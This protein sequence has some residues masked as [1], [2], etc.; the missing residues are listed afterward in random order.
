MKPA[1]LL[2]ALCGFVASC[3]RTSEPSSENEKKSVPFTA[4]ELIDRCIAYHDPQ[5]LWANFAG[6]LRCVNVRSNVIYDEILEINN[7]TGYYK[8]SLKA[9]DAKIIRGI[10]NNVAFRSVDGDSTLTE[11]EMQ[12][13]G[14]TD[15]M[16]RFWN[17]V[18][19]NHFGLPMEIRKSGISLSDSVETEKFDDRECFVIKGTGKKDSVVNPFYEGEWKIYIDS[20]NFSVRGIEVKSAMFNTTYIIAFEGTLNLNG[21]IL[22]KVKIGSDKNDPW[23]VS[24]DVFTAVAN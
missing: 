10:K 15:P 24:T 11:K 8:S 23:L 2:L 12:D 17:T 9:P 1:L 14:L 5:G 22:P 4:S 6:K 7:T 18:H 20:Q 16:I 3:N 19:I 21:I 13:R